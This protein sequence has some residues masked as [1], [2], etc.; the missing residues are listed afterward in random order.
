MNYEIYLRDITLGIPYV[1]GVPNVAS[2]LEDGDIVT[3]DGNIGIVTV[4][5]QEFDI[6]FAKGR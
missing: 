4:G 1:N 2:I 5:E 3:V 6:E